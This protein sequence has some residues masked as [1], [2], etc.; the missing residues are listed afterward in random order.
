MQLLKSF[1]DILDAAASAMSEAAGVLKEKNRRAAR[2]NRAKTVL[3][4][5]YQAAERELLA[6][7]RYYYE[8]LRDPENPV[9][10]GHCA[11]LDEIARR[12]E[13]TRACLESIYAGAGCC[14]EEPQRE[15]VT[16]ED[17]TRYDADPE[18]ETPPEGPRDESEDLPFEG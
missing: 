7:G 5:E 9:A 14:C 15:E 8:T 10:E 18:A 11:E 17:V 1:Q 6:L 13:E 16:L 3:R 2:I 12:V 4:C